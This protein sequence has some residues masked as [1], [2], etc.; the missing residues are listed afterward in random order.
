MQRFVCYTVLCKDWCFPPSSCKDVYFIL[1]HARIYILPYIIQGFVFPLVSC[2]DVYFIF[3]KG[4]LFYPALCKN[5]YFTLYYA[6]L[7]IPRVMQGYIFYHAF[8]K[9]L[10]FTCIMLGCVG[11]VFTLHDIYIYIYIIHIFHPTCKAM[12]FTLHYKRMC[13]SPCIRICIH[14][15]L[16]ND[17]PYLLSSNALSTRVWRPLVPSAFHISQILKASGFLPHWMLL[18]P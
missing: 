13:I 2:K 18:S 4:F 6:R 16:R 17:P 14:P 12:Y 3:I 7:C 15:A 10:C 11:C 8:C 9:D 1:Y 5:L